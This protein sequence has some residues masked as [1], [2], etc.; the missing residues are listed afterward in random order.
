MTATAL[1]RLTES[2]EIGVRGGSELAD[3]FSG[4]T[5]GVLGRDVPRE[6]ILAAGMTPVRLFPAVGLRA[7]ALEE[8]V[9]GSP[10]QLDPVTASQFSRLLRG[11]FDW[12][13]HLVLAHDTPAQAAVFAI[14]RE[15]ER[16][17]PDRQF[18]ER[19]FLD[20][21]HL[22]YRTTSS[23]N[24]RRLSD[25]RETLRGWSG[26]ALSDDDLRSAL[27]LTATQRQLCR[28]VSELR[29]GD[30]PVLRGSDALR[31]Y[32]AAMTMPVQA[33]IDL[34]SDLLRELDGTPPL[35]GIPVLVTGG[36]Q[37]C[38][39]FYELL[40][41]CGAVIV[42]ED[43]D[44]GDRWWDGQ[45]RLT[46]DPL[47]GLTD[48][49]HR[50][51]PAASGYGIADRAEY[52]AARAAASRAVAVIAFVLDGD[53]APRWDLPA[54]ERALAVLGIPVLRLIRQHLPP[55]DPGSLIETVQTFLQGLPGRGAE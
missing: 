18:P 1:Q 20:L 10:L 27:R 37:P 47:D 31:I 33:H 14:M 34:V 19:W 16:F 45:V 36:A 28:S 29:C 24:R 43:D 8:F 55:S 6:L 5:V 52:T 54:Q 17:E 48:A 13:N 49:Y 11:D 44:W 9:A 30:R 40:E 41:S 22:P 51:P 23:Y 12:I 39:D 25:L 38:T 46:A 21:L 7:A 2:Y 3:R 4:P 50:G 42:G 15:I 32:G 26:R 53:N 35:Q